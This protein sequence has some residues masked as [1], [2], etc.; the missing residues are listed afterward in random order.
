MNLNQQPFAVGVLVCEPQGTDTNIEHKFK[1][2]V[3]SAE[4]G[5]S[6][7]LFVFFICLSFGCFHSLPVILGPANYR[8]RLTVYTAAVSVIPVIRNLQ[9]LRSPTLQPYSE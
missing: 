4:Q 5:P 7:C 6:F 8:L 2:R 9:L 1:P 3:Q